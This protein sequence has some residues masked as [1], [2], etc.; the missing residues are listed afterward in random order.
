MSEIQ[1]MK[2]NK[3]GVMPVPKLLLSMSLPMM[4]SMLVQALYNVVDSIFVAR[5]S[6]DAFTAVNLAFPIQNFMIALG[7]GTGVG[8]NALLSRNLGEKRFDNANKAARNGIFLA[9]CSYIAVAVFGLLGSRFFYDSQIENQVVREAGYQYLTIITT[10]SIGIFM[11]ITLERLLQATGNTFYTMITQGAGAIVNIILDPLLIFGIGVFPEMGVAGAAVATVG[12]QLVSMSLA[13]YY[14][15]AKNKEININMR[16]FVPDKKVIANIYKVGI[17]SIIMQSI[18]SVMTLGFNKI[19][20]RFSEVAVNVFGAY[21]KI[22]SFIFMPV[23]GLNNGMIPILAYNY[24]ARYKKRI[25]DTIR[26]G[27]AIS[28]GI[29]VAGF[30][31]FQFGAPFI[32]ETLFAADQQMLSIGVP[33]LRII[34]ISFIFAGYDIIISS[35]LQAFGEGISSMLIS[36]ARQLVVILPVAYL[37]SIKFGLEA[38]WW[39]FPIAE[40]V[41]GILCTIFFKW[42]Y[43]KKIKHL[44]QEKRL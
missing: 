41:S 15:I 27:I 1:T 12:G 35:L 34:S 32:L 3:M 6:Q 19:L 2:E 17:P 26:L 37:F 38:V 20:L 33:A 22:N 36:I 8:I 40:I 24:G 28:C 10:A 31:L 5:Y 25:I 18:G 43:E 11:A 39:S 21:F 9:V 13:A 42:L 4:I 44:D 30:L 14:N 16:G 29:M 7:A 23:F